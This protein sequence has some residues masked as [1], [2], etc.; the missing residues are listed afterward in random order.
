MEGK[1]SRNDGRKERRTRRKTGED[2][3]DKGENIKPGG[4]WKE[5]EEE[6]RD[7]GKVRR[8]AKV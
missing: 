4:G 2:K 3:K 6:W 8:N 5:T 1:R 7:G